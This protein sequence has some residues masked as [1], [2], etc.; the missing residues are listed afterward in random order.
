MAMSCPSG[1]PREMICKDF[2]LRLFGAVL[3]NLTTST[4]CL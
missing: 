4:I 3:H 1:S 2:Q